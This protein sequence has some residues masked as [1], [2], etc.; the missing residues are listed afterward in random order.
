MPEQHPMLTSTNAAAFTKSS[1]LISAA[2]T[3]VMMGGEGRWSSTRTLILFIIFPTDQA[4]GLGQLVTTD[5][6]SYH[7]GLHS[8]TSLLTAAAMV[9]RL[10]PKAS[11]DHSHCIPAAFPAQSQPLGSG[12][13]RTERGLE[14]AGEICGGMYRP[15]FPGT[16]VECATCSGSNFTGGCSPSIRKRGAKVSSAS[17]YFW[18]ASQKTGALSLDLHTVDR[19][20]PNLSTLTSHP[21]PDYHCTNI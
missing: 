4:T 15:C 16:A 10:S 6:H 18:M 19:N 14:P 9:I 5:K 20:R 3:S 12:L 11:G 21:W 7:H 8:H 2:V 13:G 17:R 1:E